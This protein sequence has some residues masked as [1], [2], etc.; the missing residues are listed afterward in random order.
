MNFRDLTTTFD[1]SA[2]GT[3]AFL[4]VKR[5]TLA[6][7]RDDPDRAAA[8]FLIYGFARSYVILHDDEPIT[9]DFANASKNQL[10]GYM[11]TVDAALD[12]GAEALLGALREIVNHYLHSGKPF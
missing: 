4:E 2:P 12:Q 9:P 10:L 5:G 6:L 1:A 3:D 11:R 7:V 8:Y